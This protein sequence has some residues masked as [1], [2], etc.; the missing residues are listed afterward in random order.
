M[1]SVEAGS[2]ARKAGLGKPA[3]DDHRRLKTTEKPAGHQLGYAAPAQPTQKNHWPGSCVADWLS[4][5]FLE[6]L[7]TFRRTFKCT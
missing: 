2:A 6:L 5:C 7:R 1:P 4:A 3:P